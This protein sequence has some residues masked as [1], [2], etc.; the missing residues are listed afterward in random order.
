MWEIILGQ[1]RVVLAI[2]FLGVFLLYLIGLILYRLYL[3][4]IARFPGPKLAAMTYLFEGYYDVVK[5]GK[6]TFKIRDLHTEYGQSPHHSPIRMRAQAMLLISIFQDQSFESALL[7]CTSMIPN[8]TISSTIEKAGG[9][10]T[11]SM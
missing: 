1:R 4:P 2:L 3:S 11:R 10:R 9:R 8:I 5:R 6:Y 7:S